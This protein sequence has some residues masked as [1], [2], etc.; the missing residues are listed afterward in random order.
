MITDLR[1][2]NSNYFLKG[3]GVYCA[4]AF[5]C[6]FS[7]PYLLILMKY[8]CIHRHFTDS[9]SCLKASMHEFDNMS[10]NASILYASKL[11]AYHPTSESFFLFYCVKMYLFQ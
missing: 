3:S 9:V 4:V 2:N 10:I 8:R 1:L 7:C 11:Y 6:W 5:T